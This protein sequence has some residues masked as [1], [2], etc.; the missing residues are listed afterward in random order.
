RVD[1]ELVL[2]VDT[3]N[4]MDREELALQRAGYVQAL[5]DPAFVHAVLSGT[6]G[7]IAVTYFEWS[8]TIREG[9]RIP[10]QIIDGPDSA[11]V[12]AA[13]LAA[14]PL[15][16]LP[17]GG[18]SISGAVDFASGLFEK[19]AFHGERRVIDISGDGPNNSGSP[20][21]AARDAAVSRG[22]IINGLPILIRPSQMIAHAFG[23]LDLYYADCVTGGPG[24]FVLPIH[25]A[26][27]FATAI[28]YKLILEVSGLGAWP[29]TTYAG[30]KEPIDCLIG[31]HYG[32]FYP[33]P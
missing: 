11:M 2:A 17:G 14:Q 23:T 22:I 24:S 33:D 3:S 30:K 16:D 20:V 25:A 10:W 26:S 15:G 6:E 21:A 7:R 32:L 31:E 29:G 5:R 19:S 9:S 4:S 12:F 1:L 13:K 8:E 27:E 18:T 28:R